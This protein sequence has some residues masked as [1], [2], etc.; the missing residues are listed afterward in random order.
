MGEGQGGA[1]AREAHTLTITGREKVLITGVD[2]VDFFSEELVCARTELGTLQV[3][4]C[5]PHMVDLS[6]E[7]GRLLVE[8]QVAGVSYSEERQPKSLWGRLLQ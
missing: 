3:K 6:G 8:G 2:Q 1:R 4:G 7:R 5:G